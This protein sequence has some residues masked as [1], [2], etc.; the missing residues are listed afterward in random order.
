MEV[1]CCMDPLV[2]ERKGSGRVG[3]EAGK[4]LEKLVSQSARCIA[5]FC[6]SFVAEPYW[7]QLQVTRVMSYH[8]MSWS[9][10]NRQLATS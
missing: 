8:G 3:N 5:D 4:S 1:T 6:S 9:V 10:S 7:E 2:A